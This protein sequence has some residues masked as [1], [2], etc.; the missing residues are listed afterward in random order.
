M[1]DVLRTH[2]GER[3]GTR[4]LRRLM[5]ESSL[6]GVPLKKRRHRRRQINDEAVPDLVRRD[7]V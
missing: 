2:H 7:F 3:I 6:W 5:K 1:R 4:R